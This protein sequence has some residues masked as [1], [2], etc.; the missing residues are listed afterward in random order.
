M[1]TE[2]QLLQFRAHQDTVSTCR[3][4]DHDR[5]IVTTSHDTTI[6]FWVSVREITDSAHVRR[7]DSHD[8]FL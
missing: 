4:L 6:A 7:S 2:T 8:T 3:F 1:F 5:L